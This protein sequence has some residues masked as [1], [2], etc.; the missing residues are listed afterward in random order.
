M[1]EKRESA[2][3]KILNTKVLRLQSKILG[4]YYRELQKNFK[5]QMKAKNLTLANE[6]NTKKEQINVHYKLVQKTLKDKPS[7]KSPKSSVKMKFLSQK[8]ILYR[9]ASYSTETVKLKIGGACFKKGGEYLGSET[10]T[11]IPD[12]LIGKKISFLS[13]DSDSSSG[14][15]YYKPHKSGYIY[16]VGSSIYNAGGAFKVGEMKTSGGRRFNV[17]KYYLQKSIPFYFSMSQP[18]ESFAITER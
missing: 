18:S 9:S 2:S 4:N 1:L 7:V 11:T 10:W 12:F 13:H 14:R 3:L 16:Y 8:D 15:A 6:I 5:E 17:Y